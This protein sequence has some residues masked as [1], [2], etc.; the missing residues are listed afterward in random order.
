MRYRQYSLYFLL[1]YLPSIDFL[2]QFRILVE[3]GGD[4][5]LHIQ[6][7][8]LK[9]TGATNQSLYMSDLERLNFDIHAFKKHHGKY[10]DVRSQTA[11]GSVVVRQYV[12]IQ[13]R[14]VNQQDIALTE[15]FWIKMAINKPHAGF[16]L[17]LS[18]REVRHQLFFAT[19]ADNSALFVARDKT[20]LM[21]IL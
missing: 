2:A 18:G 13:M 8:V 11:D 17:R 16:Q 9:D 5:D 1:I 6:V 3:V 15:W 21:S 20:A 19:L 7:L 12:V 14:V 10:G 4:D